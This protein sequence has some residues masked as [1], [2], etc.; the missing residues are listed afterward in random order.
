MMTVRREKKKKTVIV[1]ITS[2]DRDNSGSLPGKTMAE[3]PPFCEE[4]SEKPEP[5]RVKKKKR[6]ESLFGP[7]G[8]FRFHRSF[9]PLELNDSFMGKAW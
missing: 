1:F 6:N 9:F 7:N 5:S 4:G 8:S 2:T 3:E